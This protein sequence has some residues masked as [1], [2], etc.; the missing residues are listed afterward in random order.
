MTMQKFWMCECGESHRS[1]VEACEQVKDDG[2]E[3]TDDTD[4][5]KAVLAD[6][7]DVKFSDGYE[8]NRFEATTLCSQTRRQ[9]RRPRRESLTACGP[10]MPHSLLARLASLSL[11]R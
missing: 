5:R 10:S 2:E 4:E 3:I 1:D 11:R 9:T 6:Y 8:D 7:L